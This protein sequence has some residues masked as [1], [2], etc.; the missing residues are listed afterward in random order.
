[1]SHHCRVLGPLN[2]ISNLNLNAGTAKRSTV[3]EKLK[4]KLELAVVNISRV[5]VSFGLAITQHSTL[6]YPC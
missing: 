6:F 5:R 4:N 2:V 1:M 3:L